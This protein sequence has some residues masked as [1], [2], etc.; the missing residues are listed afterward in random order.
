MLLT[1]EPRPE[2]EEKIYVEMISRDGSTICI[3]FRCKAD[4]DYFQKKY[5]KEFKD[6]KTD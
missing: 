5:I 2:K 1:T 3:R 4:C 6:V